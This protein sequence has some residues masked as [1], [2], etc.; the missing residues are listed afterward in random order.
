MTGNYSVALYCIYNDPHDLHDEIIEST[1]HHYTPH[2]IDQ[3]IIISWGNKA[4]NEIVSVSLFPGEM[5]RWIKETDE[6]KK[7]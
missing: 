5:K 1:C 2:G 3:N 6:A 4:R 7:L